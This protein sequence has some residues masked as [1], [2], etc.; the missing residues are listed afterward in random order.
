MHFPPNLTHLTT[1]YLDKSRC[2]KFLPNTG[3]VTI[4]CSDLVSKW[5]GH[6]ATT[7]L[8]R[9]HCQTC[10]GCSETIF[11]VST[12]RHLGASARE[13]RDTVAFLQERERDAR[14]ASSS[15]RLC[16]STRHIF[17]HKF[18]QFWADLSWQLITVLNKPYSV[19]C[20]L[21]QSSN[22]LLQIIY[23]YTSLFTIKMV[24]QLR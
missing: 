3:F 23:I 18:W 1:L 17:E 10:A 5:R 12:G 8:L 19:Y 7:L 20:V 21:I 4:C 9:G 6:V 15:R 22:T 14:N 2:F 11:Y 24:V 16:P 13:W